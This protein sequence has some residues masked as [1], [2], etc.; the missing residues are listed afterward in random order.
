MSDDRNSNTNGQPK[1]PGREAT[2]KPLPRRFYKTVVIGR[3]VSGSARTILLDGRAARTPG[4]REL[5]LATKALAEA[6][7]TEWDVQ[8]TTIDPATMP[9]T[10]LVNTAID[11]VE[12]QMAEVAADIVKYAG[13]D[14]LCY[15]ADYPEGLAAR[16]RTLWDPVLAWIAE[17]HAASFTLA[18]GLMPV[19]QSDEAA[20][21]IAEAV[22]PLDPLRLTA[23]HV[24]TTLM[25]SALLALAVLGGR[26]TPEAAWEAAH[27]DED[28]QTAE[29]GE[30]ADASARRERRWRE[31]QAA[32]A[33]IRLL[34]A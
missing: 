14:L 8:Q 6:V 13:S 26:L 27:V 24:M 5:R 34:A 23:L 3:A 31:I 15:R 29:W 20:A 16:Q 4:K 33:L 9:L 21:R 30:D 7:A 12:A 18:T 19:A 28:W 10:R 2:Q 25:G 32:S 11:G 22:A 17:H 1:A